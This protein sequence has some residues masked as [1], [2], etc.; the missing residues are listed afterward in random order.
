MEATGDRPVLDTTHY[1]LLQ[2]GCTGHNHRQPHR[3]QSPIT[4]Q[5]VMVLRPPGGGRGA[6]VPGYPL[7]PPV[8]GCAGWES[9]NQAGTK[10]ELAPCPD[11]WFLPAR[12]CVRSNGGG[13]GDGGICE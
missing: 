2:R 13:G 8:C 11:A 9:E 6:V 4:R 10:R 1:E 7:S 5:H 12:T 3:D